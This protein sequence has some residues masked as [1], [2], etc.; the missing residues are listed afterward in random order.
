[1]RKLIFIFLI[2]ISLKITGQNSKSIIFSEIMFSSA[3]NSEFIELYNLSENEIDLS[4]FTI[5]YLSYTDRIVSAGSGTILKPKTFAVIF[6]GDYDFQN[7]IYSDKIVQDALI[8]KISDNSFGSSGM[9]NTSDRTLILLHNND[10]SDVYTYSAN[11]I[12]RISDEKIDLSGNNSNENWSNSKIQDGTPGAINSVSPK[13]F[14]I[15]LIDFTPQFSI[16]GNSIS[17]LI[18]M[19]NPASD[20]ANFSYS[21]YEDEN[22]DSLS[23]NHLYTSG[24]YFI[25][26]NDSLQIQSEFTIQNFKSSKGILIQ[27]NFE[28]DEDTT[29]NFIY[30]IIQPFYN[31]ND[32]VINEIMYQ[33]QNGEPEWIEIYNNSNDTID[34]FNWSINDLFTTPTKVSVKEKLLILPQSYFVFAKD[35]TIILHHN[36]EDIDFHKIILP[37]LNNDRDAVIIKDAYGNLIDSVYYNS[38]MGGRNGFSLERILFEESSNDAGNWGTS[39]DIEQST[40]ARKNSLAPKNF[41][42]SINDIFTIPQFP[43]KDEEFQIGVRISN[44][45]ISTAENILLHFF[46]K[47]LNDDEFLFFDETMI[48]RLLPNETVDIITRNS[49]LLNDTFEIKIVLIFENDEDSSDNSQS[50]IID[51]SYN[52]NSIIIN[53]F[54]NIPNAGFPEWIEIF[55]AGNSEINLK[56]WS[57]SDLLPNETGAIIS[58]DDLIIYPG[59]YLIIA[60]APGQISFTDSINIVNAKFGALGNSE[61]GIILREA[62]GKIIDSISYNANWKFKRGFS[63][64]RI[65]DFSK[66]TISENW[67]ISF[68]Q[69]G[70]PGKINSN[71]YAENIDQNSLVINEIMIAPAAGNAEFI[72]LYNITDDSVNLAGLKIFTDQENYLTVSSLNFIL[73]PGSFFVI[74]DDSSI[75]KNYE[76]QNDLVFIPDEN[77][78]LRNSS[79]SIMLK[80]FF[81]KTIDSIT[82]N[83]DWYNKNIA[84]YSQNSLEKI[85]PLL[86]TNNKFNWSTSVNPQGATPGKVNSINSSNDNLQ[87]NVSISPNPFSPDDDGFEDFTIIN[88][89]LSNQISQ[90]RLRIFD[91]KG[92]LVRTI[93]ENRASANTGSIVFDGRNDEGN[94]LRMGIYIVLLEAVE[95]NSFKTETLKTVVVIARKL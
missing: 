53:E 22:L 76:I 4:Q 88:Y 90:I 24:Y 46:H 45:G 48:Q 66:P 31:Y 19:I 41:N 39:K 89:N 32:V 12:S 8:L 15:S 60:N 25:S 51:P 49:L 94:P 70:T 62:N 78:D 79:G 80:D 61:D 20:N 63:L 42:V 87:K 81:N 50:I 44:K 52:Y 28:E 73:P 57:I 40:P 23:E 21:I 91:S 18:K 82:Y 1:M 95:T 56:N 35:T 27:L 29:N 5:Q 92:R 33:P 75:F 67:N 69:N 16:T 17:F 10:T 11:N 30:K 71:F 7:G 36:I 74:A 77:F 64:E 13:Q 93:E 86:D 65:N 59:E 9:A 34:V 58:S 38:Q 54:M 68:I 26:S 84:N 37:V 14:D 72:E 3:D 43:E 6:E 55:N 2:F 83:E 47:N 85:S